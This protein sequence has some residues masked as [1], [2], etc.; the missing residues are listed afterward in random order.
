MDLSTPPDNDQNMKNQGKVVEK[1]DLKFTI[2]NMDYSKE[3]STTNSEKHIRISES[4][5]RKVRKFVKICF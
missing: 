5:A 3:L 2:I 1:L 4:L